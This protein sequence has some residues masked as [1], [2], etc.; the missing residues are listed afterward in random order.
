MYLLCLKAN[1]KAYQ[2][3]FPVSMMAVQKI[4]F[5]EVQAVFTVPHVECLDPKL[6][7]AVI[8]FVVANRQRVFQML[9]RIPVFGLVPRP[10]QHPR[11]V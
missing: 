9:Y 2:T 7:G 4:S 5:A 11:A 1:F 3:W 6:E 8:E 10:K